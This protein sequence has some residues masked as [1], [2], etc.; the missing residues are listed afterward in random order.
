MKAINYYAPEAFGAWAKNGYLFENGIF[1]CEFKYYNKPHYI[2]RKYDFNNP[3]ET[4]T[5]GKNVIDHFSNSLTPGAINDY[6]TF[7]KE[8]TIEKDFEEI[9]DNILSRNVKFWHEKHHSSERLM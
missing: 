9:R 7:Q 4:T 2:C 5:W 3:P 1:I 6:Q 8:E